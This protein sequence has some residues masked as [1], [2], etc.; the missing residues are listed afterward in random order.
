MHARP[1]NRSSI[2]RASCPRKPG[3]DSGQWLK[4]P[5][6]PTQLQSAA[7]H[8]PALS[9]TSASFVSTSH[10][11]PHPSRLPSSCTRHF[12]SSWLAR[13]RSA[14]VVA[15]NRFQFFLILIH[16]RF[17]AGPPTYTRLGDL[18]TDKSAYTQH[19]CAGRWPFDNP[20]ALFILFVAF[21]FTTS[22]S[23]TKSRLWPTWHDSLIHG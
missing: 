7:G 3:A 9:F 20:S 21:L 6:I 8:K 11:L 15:E 17:L 16:S 5:R 14:F 19:R 1:C 18:P 2:C 10:H 12:V 13:S 4:R 23:V 22:Y